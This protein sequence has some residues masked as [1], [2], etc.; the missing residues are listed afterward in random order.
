MF[1]LEKVFQKNDETYIVINRIIYAIIL[2]LSS[3]LAFYLRENTALFVPIEL[4]EE[5]N[6]LETK[7]FA[8]ANI[9]ILIF[10]FILLFTTKV[11]KYKKGILFFIENDLKLITLT[12]V[13]L[14]FTAVIFKEAQK[15]SYGFEK[16]AQQVGDLFQDNQGPFYY[17]DG[18]LMA[19]TWSDFKNLTYFNLEK[20][21]FFTFPANRTFVHLFS[22]S[23]LIILPN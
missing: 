12:F 13:G 14:V 15:T 22:L 5:K 10:F 6:F 19:N 18:Q 2:Y 7:Y 21:G 16:I 20:F 17:P 23:I 1:N 9:E 11:K 4:V 3:I 8:A